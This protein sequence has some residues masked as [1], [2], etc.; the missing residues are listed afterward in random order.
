MPAAYVW[1]R[2]EFYGKLMTKIATRDKERFLSGTTLYEIYKTAGHHMG[3]TS[4]R[5]D[6]A[7]AGY[8]STCSAVVA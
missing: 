6:C 1:N 2:C 4:R 7:P 8:A 3:T 5:K